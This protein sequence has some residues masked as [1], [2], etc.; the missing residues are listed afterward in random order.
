MSMYLVLA[1]MPSNNHL[2]TAGWRFIH[3]IWRKPA[4]GD[5]PGYDTAGP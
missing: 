4:A 1:A 2:L 5:S 3:A